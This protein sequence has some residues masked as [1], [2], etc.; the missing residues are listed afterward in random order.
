MADPTMGVAEFETRHTVRAPIADAEP[1]ESHGKRYMPRSVEVRYSRKTGE[2]WKT[3][4]ATLFGP[5]IRQDGT[6]GTREIQ[7]WFFR[8]E[9]PAWLADFVD[10]NHPAVSR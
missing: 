2:P 9:V 10:Q 7:E 3:S 5:Q 1:R 4:A 8:T 6:V